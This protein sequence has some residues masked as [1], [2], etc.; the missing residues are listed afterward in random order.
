MS[1]NRAAV[2]ALWQGV[3][4]VSV[5]VLTWLVFTFGVVR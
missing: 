1:R 2:V 3:V 4:Y 5:A